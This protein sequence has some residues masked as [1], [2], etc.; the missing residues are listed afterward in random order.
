[1]R[2][3]LLLLTPIL[4]AMTLVVA[5]PPGHAH[6]TAEELPSLAP[7]VKEIGPAVV[8]IQVTGEPKQMQSRPQQPQ[9]PHPFFDHPFFKEFFGDREFERRRPQMRR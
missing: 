4:L 1:M 5:A 9:Q 7:L 8:N 3:P 6:L 2:F